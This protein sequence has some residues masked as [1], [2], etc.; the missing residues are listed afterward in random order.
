MN[1]MDRVR[2][3][4]EVRSLTSEKKKKLKSKEE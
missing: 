3:V 2:V 4:E 1:L